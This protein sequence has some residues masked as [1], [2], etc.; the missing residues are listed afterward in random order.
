MHARVCVCVCVCVCASMSFARVHVCACACVHACL[1]VCV[2]VLEEEVADSRCRLLKWPHMQ[3]TTLFLSP[4]LSLPFALSFSLSGCQRA[5]RVFVP[6]EKVITS[7]NERAAA[8]YI[9]FEVRQP[10][11]MSIEHDILPSPHPGAPANRSLSLCLRR[12]MC[13]L[14]CRFLFN[15]ANP[16]CCHPSSQPSRH[17]SVCFALV[18][19]DGSPPIY[20]SL[21]TCFDEGFSTGWIAC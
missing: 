15:T 1:C 6:W 19:S 12:S 18:L 13:S 11:T 9:C 10:L 21:L 2:C 20:V 5:T 17:L 7:P 14:T 4:F 16:C 3:E 8:T